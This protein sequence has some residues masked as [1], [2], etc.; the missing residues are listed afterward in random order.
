[1]REGNANMLYGST[2]LTK[3]SSKIQCAQVEIG[4]EPHEP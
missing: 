3:L 1:M 4:A 2:G